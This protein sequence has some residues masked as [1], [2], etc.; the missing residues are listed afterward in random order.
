M[1]TFQATEWDIEDLDNPLAA[2]RVRDVETHQATTP[3]EADLIQSEAPV[4]TTI[5]VAVLGPTSIRV[6]FP[7]PAK[8]NSALVQA[9]NYVITPSRN[10]YSVTPEAVAEPNYVDLEIDEQLTGVSYEI[11]V[12]GV[13]KA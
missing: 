7:Q 4:F 13:E 1:P 9:G 6:I 8:N 12:Q 2:V 5:T 3:I 11:E 10:V